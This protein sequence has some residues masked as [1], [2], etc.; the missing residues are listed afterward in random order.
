MNTTNDIMSSFVLVSFQSEGLII[1]SLSEVK[2]LRSLRPGKAASV[3]AKQ[4]PVL[5]G[6]GGTSDEAVCWYFACTVVNR[7]LL[8]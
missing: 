8:L 2:H 3:G 6:D 4:R 7:H 5:G 1:K